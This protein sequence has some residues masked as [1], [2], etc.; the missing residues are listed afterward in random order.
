MCFTLRNVHQMYFTK[1][2]S[3]LWKTKCLVSDYD[4]KGSTLYRLQNMSGH[5]QHY[6]KYCISVTDA[7]CN[8]TLLVQRRKLELQSAFFTIAH[9]LLHLYRPSESHLHHNSRG[10]H[11]EFACPHLIYGLFLGQDAKKRIKS[12]HLKTKQSTNKAQ[13]WGCS[14]SKVKGNMTVW[15]DEF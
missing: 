4:F 8:Y 10:L 11:A 9:Q 12:K 1:L 14:S 7:T 3:F 5:C 13:Q 15:K 6:D 2:P